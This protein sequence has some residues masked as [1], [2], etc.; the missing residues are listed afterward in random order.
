M[1]PTK[2]ARSP[3]D[4]RRMVGGMGEVGGEGGDSGGEEVVVADAA[5][6]DDGFGVDDRAELPVVV[7]R[8]R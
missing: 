7:D 4:E 8:S 3:R 6:E 5:A 2:E 1:A